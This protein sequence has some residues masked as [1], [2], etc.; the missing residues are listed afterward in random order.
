M[1][2]LDYLHRHIFLF[3]V[4]RSVSLG[5]MRRYLQLAYLFHQCA[6]CLLSRDSR[7]ADCAVRHP[8]VERPF[9]SIYILFFYHSIAP[10]ICCRCNRRVCLFLCYSSSAICTSTDGI[11]ANGSSFDV[12]WGHEYWTYSSIIVFTI[13][14]VDVKSK[15]Q[16]DIN[17]TKTRVDNNNFMLCE[18]LS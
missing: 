5:R 2:T 15:W 6:K 1:P 3:H 9:S 14:S 18:K 7:I 4:Y 17:Y 16:K 12:D 13:I 11:S 10:A 8:G